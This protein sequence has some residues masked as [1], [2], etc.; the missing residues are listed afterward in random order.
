MKIAFKVQSEVNDKTCVLC[1]IDDTV[2]LQVTKRNK[3]SC[4]SAAMELNT[5][6]HCVWAGLA[7]V[8]VCTALV[9]VKINRSEVS[10]NVP[11]DIQVLPNSSVFLRGMLYQ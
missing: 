1:F 5:N 2:S 6:K 9:Y 10:L 4:N 11:Y 8:L 7:L 3:A